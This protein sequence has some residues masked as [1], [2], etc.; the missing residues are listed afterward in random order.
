M[1]CG[2]LELKSICSSVFEVGAC[3][4]ITWVN[5]DDLLLSTKLIY[6]PLCKMGITDFIS[7]SNCKVQMTS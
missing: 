7:W 5:V 3:H 2:S 4:F 1:Y 6:I